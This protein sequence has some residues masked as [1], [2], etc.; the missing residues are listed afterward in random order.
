M[1]ARRNVCSKCGSVNYLSK[2]CKVVVSPII[3]PSMLTLVYLNFNGLAQ[4]PFLP[5]PY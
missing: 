1:Y 4:M 2:H 3:S 5:N